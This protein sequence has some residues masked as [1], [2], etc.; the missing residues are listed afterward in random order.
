VEY[1]TSNTGIFIVYIT[2]LL[3]SYTTLFD[4]RGTSNPAVALS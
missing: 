2:Q 4:S 3:L 1:N